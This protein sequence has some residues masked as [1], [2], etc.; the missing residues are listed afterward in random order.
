MIGMEC[1]HR[2]LTLGEDTAV[3][4]MAKR[5]LNVKATGCCDCESDYE[6]QCEGAN[7]F[8]VTFFFKFPIALCSQ[9]VKK[10]SPAESLLVLKIPTT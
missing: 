10:P 5:R 9:Q 4:N 3:Y 7:R 1:H 8:P 6:L 2:N